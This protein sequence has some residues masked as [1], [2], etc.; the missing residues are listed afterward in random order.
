MDPL[1]PLIAYA[2]NFHS[3]AGEDG[4]LQELCRRIGIRRNHYV[5]IGAHDGVYMSN[6]EHLRRHGWVGVCYEANRVRYERLKAHLKQYR[7]N[8]CEQSTATPIN[9]NDLC[10]AVIGIDIL[11]IDIDGPDYH[12][13]DALTFARPTIVVIEIMARFT[14][15]YFHIPSPQAP[16][17]GNASTDDESAVGASFSAMVGL[18]VEK[19]YRLAAYTGLN[20]I[21][22]VDEHAEDAGCPDDPDS[23]YLDARQRT[24]YRK[25]VE[26]KT[27]I[28]GELARLA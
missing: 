12:V 17:I 22:V 8:D 14:L 2:E 26:R 25:L 10:S 11:S 15:G 23:L 21:F 1:T 27:A 5:D 24:A 3:Q 19:G 4:I 7:D 13:W 20:C 18:G 9:V 6:T 16:A 28:R